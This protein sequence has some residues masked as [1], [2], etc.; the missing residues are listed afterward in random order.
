MSD[1]DHCLSRRSFVAGSTLMAVSALLAA[2]GGADSSAPTNVNV[3]TK[4]SDYTALA[5]VGGMA[6]L[7]GTSTPIAVVRTAANTFRAFSLICPHEAGSVGINGTGFLCSK[8]GA[9]FNSSGTWTGGER[10]TNLHE[11]TVA[12]DA[13]A[14]TL[15][16]TS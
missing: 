8:H 2:C 11:F 13:T 7:T 14:G 5:S 4:V 12:Y 9:T 6:R 1:C 3:T 10:T 15:T 16:I